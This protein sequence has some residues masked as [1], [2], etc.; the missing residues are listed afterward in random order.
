MSKKLTGS[1]EKALA[2]SHDLLL[3]ALDLRAPT[4]RRPG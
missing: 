4:L 2:L 3:F 1:E